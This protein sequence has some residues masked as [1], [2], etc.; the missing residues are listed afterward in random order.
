[1]NT[2]TSRAVLGL[3]VAAIGR[4]AYI[5]L[6]HDVDL[7]DGREVRDLRQRTREL[8]QAAWDAGVRYFDAARSYGR[9]EEFLGSWLSEHPER[10][11]A[12]TIG[13]K[14][15]YT[16]VGD[17]RIDAEQH[18]VKDHSL[19]T[20]TRQWPQTLAALGSAPQVYLVHSL[21]PDSPVLGDTALLD[22][23]NRLAEDG[24]R[25]GFSTSGPQQG[26]VIRA[27]L[28]LGSATPFSAVQATWNL[29]EDSAGPALARAHEAGWFV[30]V[31]EAVANG[32]LTT[33]GQNEAL[34]NLATDRGTTPDALA[35]A[36]ALDQPWADVVLSGAA[37]LPQ[38]AQNLAAAH[39]P[40]LDETEVADL[41]RPPQEYWAE[42]ANLPWT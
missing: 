7:A 27:A 18:E 12:A 32:R 40:G 14:W 39:L 37:T 23:L 42:R 15:G 29:L 11:A 21:T 5:N 6:G 8:V 10:R 16:Y 24:V 3:G 28:A 19:A 4:P 9:G 22:G 13:S 17:W 25:I 33:R 1:M 30:V 38:L 35:L 20:F 41:V 2:S 34:H 26:E 31:K 36:S